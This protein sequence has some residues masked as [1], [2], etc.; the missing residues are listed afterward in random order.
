MCAP[1]RVPLGNRHNARSVRRSSKSQ[2][3]SLGLEIM[4]SR[5]PQSRSDVNQ[6]LDNGQL[7][8]SDIL[9]FFNNP[10]NEEQAWSVCF[11]CAQCCLRDQCQENY[12]ILFEH[13][14]RS[15]CL[16]RDGEVRIRSPSGPK[17][18][19]KGPPG[20]MAS[21]DYC[22]CLL[23]SCVYTVW[24]VTHCDVIMCLCRVLT[25]NHN[26]STIVMVFVFGPSPFF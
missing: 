7:P 4:A 20:G 18:S 8:F 24:S 5:P 12:Q 3:A 10:I 25:D 2:L 13:G 9:R 11:Q 19:G 1:S 16:N 15:V 6:L 26:V 22:Q 21:M 14:L 17:G 23:L